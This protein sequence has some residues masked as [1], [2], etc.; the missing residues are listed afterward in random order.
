MGGGG[1]K[2]EVWLGLG[3]LGQLR[4]SCYPP[5]WPRRPSQS[6]PMASSSQMQPTTVMMAPAA[7]VRWGWMG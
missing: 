5:P 1:F 2:L 3:L 6:V 4:W 7:A